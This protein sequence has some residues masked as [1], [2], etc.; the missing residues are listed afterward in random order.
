MKNLFSKTILYT[1]LLATIACNKNL[2][3]K[4]TQSIDQT[5][6]LNTSS[7]VLV[8]LTGA[9]ADLGASTFYGGYPFIASELLANAGELNWSGTFQQFTQINNKSIPVDNSFVANTWLSGYKAINDVNNVL[10]AI[11][12]VDASKKDRVEGEA[13][14][15]RA[16]VLFDLVRLY[17]K[18]WNDGDPT[19]NPG[20][21]I[22]LT[23]TL[24]ITADNQV[25]RDNVSAV[26]TQVIK[27]LTDAEAKLPAKNG[28]FATKAAAAGMAARVYLQKGDYTNAAA[29]ANRAIA[30][31]T[32]NG[33]SLK[34]AYADAFPSNTSG[35]TS[36]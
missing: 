15:I 12:V 35:N 23:P 17:A 4:P 25:K 3:T 36:E 9:Y 6:A 11:N 7:D 27:D 16:S 26:Y 31:A 10:A 30:S 21:P 1:G 14:F 2:D 28:F 32:T 29:A 24:G 33:L 20:V 8:A 19:T 34:S 18:S 5:A 22:V 13:K